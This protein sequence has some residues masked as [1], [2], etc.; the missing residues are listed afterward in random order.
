MNKVRSLYTKHSTHKEHSLSTP[1]VESLEG[2]CRKAHKFLPEHGTLW[3]QSKATQTCFKASWSCSSQPANSWQAQVSAAP[4]P[5]SRLAGQQGKGVRGCPGFGVAAGKAPPCRP[6]AGCGVLHWVP[7]KLLGVLSSSWMSFRFNYW[8]AQW[9]PLLCT[10]SNSIQLKR[11]C[12]IIRTLLSWIL[13]NF[14]SLTLQQGNRKFAG[15][16]PQSTAQR[17]DLFSVGNK[18][19]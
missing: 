17:K 2:S 12:P 16:Q 13:L 3:L 14:G 6:A 5:W 15:E 18:M 11:F 4:G 9:L 19:D 10:A 8:H 7:W 1:G